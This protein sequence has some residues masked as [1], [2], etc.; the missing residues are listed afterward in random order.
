MRN[1]A[2][3]P[4]L[5]TLIL[6]QAPGQPPPP[7]DPRVVFQSA[8]NALLNKDYASKAYLDL[9]VDQHAMTELQRSIS[10]DPKLGFE[11]FNLGVAY[12]RMGM[13]QEAGKEFDTEMTI[14]LPSSPCEISLFNRQHDGL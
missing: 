6:P 12:Q 9:Y 5:V 11:H 3:L 7:Q 10:L 1:P 14:S 2:L 13:L 4:I 8:Q